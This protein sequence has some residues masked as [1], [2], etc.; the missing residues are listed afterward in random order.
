MK[1]NN[2]KNAIRVARAMA[3]SMT[4]V[5][6]VALLGSCEDPL[7]AIAVENVRVASLPEYSLEMEL[8]PN[9]SANPVGIQKVKDGEPI[10]ISA[11][12]NSGYDFMG[13]DQT[14]GTGTATF[15]DYLSPSTTVRVTGGDVSI[16][17]I[18]DDTDYTITVNA[19][20]GGSVS[21]SSLAV[22]QG[23]PSGSVTALPGAE[24]NFAGWSVTAGLAS[25]IAFDPN[26]S[27]ASITVTANAGDATIQANFTKKTYILTM[28]SDTGG[29]TSPGSTA[30]TS[31]VAFA[32]IA[33][34]YPTYIF[35]GWT[36]VTG[37][38]EP[39]Y[40]NQ[41]SAS[42]TVSVT[43]GPITIKANFRK[44]SISLTEVGAW[45]Q[46]GSASPM[47]AIDAT[48]IGDYL[49]WIGYSSGSDNVVRRV[50]IATPGN[51]ISSSSDYK[52]FSGIPRG[53][54]RSGVNGSEIVVLGSSTTLYK[55][56]HATFTTTSLSSVPTGMKALHS[57]GATDYFWGIN[58]AGTAALYQ[59]SNLSA[60][61][62]MLTES[63]W[64]LEKLLPVPD[65]LLAV[66]EDNGW[67]NLVGFQGPE[68]GGPVS[69]S[70]SFIPLYASGDM[71]GGIVGRMALE[72]DSEYMS[73]P[74]YEDNQYLRLKTFEVTSLANLDGSLVS[75]LDIGSDNDYA[76]GAA[77]D[78][79]GSQ[80][81]YVAGS[82][83]GV[84]TIWI[85]DL[86]N[87]YN[88]SIVGGSARNCGLCSSS[89]GI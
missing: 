61:N 76:T 10:A 74:I 72:P 87:K 20:T 50:N 31:G 17:A 83:N 69:T 34:N 44:E 8:P 64:I 73:V 80:Y 27:T 36:K 63:G 81:A 42:T 47:D 88:P 28:S 66:A 54:I 19:G 59:H 32:I 21:Q 67:R 51:P 55:V 16:L 43:G 18:I 14:G 56:P 71:Y 78:D 30:L 11:V 46:A 24:Y 41:A 85:I 75:S 6:L 49:Y 84:A 23:Y 33:Y 5:L 60:V 26:A 12:S 45:D 52:A 40:G 2:R 9:G 7:T 68:G 1:K 65:G 3:I 15:A 53:I 39:V 89:R 70:D 48:M 35:N 77:Y 86:F 57:D 37:S 82:K 62:Y 25:G 4:I 13:W 79:L 29:Y 58:A 38:G 22:T